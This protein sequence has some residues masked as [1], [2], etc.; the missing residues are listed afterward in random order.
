MP[1]TGTIYSKEEIAKK[2]LEL[3][4]ELDKTIFTL[5]QLK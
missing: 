1:L 3:L 5:Q 2:D 4:E